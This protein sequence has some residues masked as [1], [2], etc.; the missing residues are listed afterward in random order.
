MICIALD[1]DPVHKALASGQDERKLSVAQL[2][3]YLKAQ[4]M[5]QSGEKGSLWHRCRLHFRVSSASLRASSGSDPCKMKPAELRKNVAQAGLSPIGTNDELLT[6]LVDYL[7]ANGGSAGSGGPSSGSGGGGGGGGGASAKDP[8]A[9]ARR[10]LALAEESESEPSV[11]LRIADPSLTA[12]S[13]TAVLRK[14][15]LKLSL[16]IHP[17]RLSS[18]FPDATRA[19]QVLVTA[20]ERL[21]EPTS[22]PG[23]L[24]EDDEEAPRGRGKGKGSQQKAAKI[25][26]S[27]EG[28]VRTPVH[29][30]RCKEPWGAAS[31]ATRR[32]CTSAIS[33]SRSAVVRL[34]T[35]GET[36]PC[37]WTGSTAAAGLLVFQFQPSHAVVVQSREQKA[38]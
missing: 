29:C 37:S 30:P 22:L 1:M 21:S 38:A 35:P 6:S 12:Q 36:T 5:S 17:D 31:S 13:P 25:S 14:A 3:G 32:V 16:A 34:T 4:G 23:G 15:Y 2:K 19:F 7:E 26:R 27:N 10:V 18:K 8:V 11:V 9:I 24:D 33:S 20:F 28:C